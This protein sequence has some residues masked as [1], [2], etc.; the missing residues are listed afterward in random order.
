TSGLNNQE[1]KVLVNGPLYAFGYGLSY[2]TYGYS[3]LQIIPATQD[4][5]GNIEVSLD[6]EN[7]GS[8]AG[9]EIVQ[10]YLSPDVTR[11]VYSGS[12]LRGLRKSQ[13]ETGRKDTRSIHAQ[14]S[15]SD[16]HQP[17]YAVGGRAR[18]I[19]GS[20]WSFV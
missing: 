18:P 2:T 19:S 1:K 11:L 8:R 9:D 13:L 3:N 4:R 15:G 20:G 5:T 6:V 12:A 14:P 7:T 17:G 10:L 16:D